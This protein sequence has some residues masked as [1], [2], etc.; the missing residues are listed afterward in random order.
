MK[1]KILIGVI[2]ASAIGIGVMYVVTRAHNADVQYDEHVLQRQDVSK[3]INVDAT[4]HPDIYRDITPEVP[5]RIKNVAVAINDVVT[6]G[7]VLVRLDRDAINAQIRKAQLAVERTEIAENQGRHKSSRLNSREILSLKKASEQ[8][9]QVRNELYAQ[10]KKMAIVAPISGVVTVQNARVGEVATGLMMRIIDPQ[11]LQVE[12]LI[13][14]V[15]I[16]KVQEGAPVRITFDAYPDTVVN[17]TIR[18]IDI[19]SVTLQNSTYYKA[20]IAIEYQDNI[21]VRDGMHADV[22]I[23]FAHREQVLA[24]PRDFAQKDAKGYFVL[25]RDDDG[26]VQRRY[27]NVG[28]VGDAFVVARDGLV[29]G[30]TIL[31]VRQD[32]M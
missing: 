16:A 28:L 4:V 31:R 10:A 19:G 17:G 8:A 20:T 6:E 7:Q 2:L 25:V 18:T 26:T 22:D 29:R 27:F 24:V 12:A 15:D 21:V 11:S 30:Q 3:T 5:L 1:N 13:P 23:V 14:E 9:R 32:T